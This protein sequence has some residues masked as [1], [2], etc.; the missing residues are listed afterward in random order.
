M[1]TTRYT[2]Y[3]WPAQTP[4]NNFRI[5]W[6]RFM[7]SGP[8]LLLGP[9][10]RLLGPTVKTVKYMLAYKF[11][12]NMYWNHLLD[13]IICSLNLLKHKA[14]LTLSYR[15]THRCGPNT[16]RHYDVTVRSCRYLESS[17]KAQFEVKEWHHPPDA[18][19]VQS[20]LLAPPT[21]SWKYSLVWPTRKH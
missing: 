2:L 19:L 1:Q 14:V 4:S 10:S 12:W 3:I 7:P 21:P 15:A 16:C 13:I 6:T 5:F 18:G 20:T 11:L 8:M 9:P 17:L